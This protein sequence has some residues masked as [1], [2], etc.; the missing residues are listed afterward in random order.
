MPGRSWMIFEGATKE[1]ASRCFEHESQGWGPKKVIEKA[2]VH[3]ISKSAKDTD[4]FINQL[5]YSTVTLF[6]K[7]NKTFCFKNYQNQ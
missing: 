3:I 7:Y 6:S 2:H 1:G 5:Y 4:K